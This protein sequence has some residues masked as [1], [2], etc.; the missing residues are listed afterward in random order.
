MKT[1]VVES[2]DAWNDLLPLLIDCGYAVWQMQFSID[3]PEGCSAVFW[4]AGHRNI[5]VVTHDPT[6]HAAILAFKA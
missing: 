2:L 1:E 3:S 4:A 6:V 5:E